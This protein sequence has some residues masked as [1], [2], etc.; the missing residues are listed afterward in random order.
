MYSKMQALMSP[1][2]DQK[3]MLS[4]GEKKNEDS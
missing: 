3:L 1:F 2:S 4:L